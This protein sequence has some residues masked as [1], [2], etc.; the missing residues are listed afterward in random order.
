[1]LLNNKTD[2]VLKYCVFC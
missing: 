2:G 1:M